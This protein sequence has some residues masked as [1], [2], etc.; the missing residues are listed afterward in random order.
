MIYGY[1]LVFTTGQSAAAQVAALTEAGAE[2]V[3][4]EAASGALTE[5]AQLRRA[6]AALDA[7]RDA[8]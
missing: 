4:R 6:I 3:F 5:R 8:A 7:G 2:K 1:A